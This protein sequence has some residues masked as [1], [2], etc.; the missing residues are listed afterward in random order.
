MILYVIVIFLGALLLFLVQPI[1][2]RLVLP[3]Y[4][5]TAVVW[6]TCLLFFQ[7]MLLA[8]YAYAHGS[9]RRLRPQWQ[10]VLHSLWLVSAA[11]TLPLALREFLKP[12]AGED[13]IFSILLML[14]AVVGLPFFILATTGP[15][16][17]AWQART[18]PNRSPYRLFAISNAGS[19]VA[20]MIY[21]F[22]I[23]PNI[24]LRMQT[25]LWSV[26]F[27]VFSVAM[28]GCGIRYFR[29][30]PDEPVAKPLPEIT[31]VLEPRKNLVVSPSTKRK[32]RDKHRMD[33]DWVVETPAIAPE[34]AKPVSRQLLMWILLATAPSALL[35]ATSGL[36]TQELSST[37]FLWVVPLSLYLLSFIIC[38]ENPRWYF[39]P[40]F[41]PLFFLT[42]VAAA[43]ITQAG[44]LAPFS[45]QLGSLS[46]AL[47]A[48]SVVCHGELERS[49]PDHNDLTT[50]YLTVAVG[51]AIGG[52]LVALV[53]PII[54]NQHYEFHLALVA[55]LFAGCSELL[56]DRRKK[57]QAGA[58]NGLILLGVA[59]SLTGIV[60]NSP[61]M[62][63]GDP[64]WNNL[65]RERN[66][67]GILTV[68]QD[69]ELRSL[70]HGR[71]VHG[72]QPRDARI[73]HLPISY[74]SAESGIGVIMRAMKAQRNKQGK[75][76]RVGV[77]GLGI[78]TMAA[79]SLEGD[80]FSFYEIDP[81]V[82]RLA[83][84]HFSYLQNAK[85]EMRVL[86]GDGRME[87]ERQWKESGSQNFDVLVLDAFSSDAVPTHLMTREALELYRRH[88]Q[89]DGVIVFHVTN[90]LLDLRRVAQGL[91]N[92]SGMQSLILNY[93]PNDK[94]L[95]SSTWFALTNDRNWKNRIAELKPP[96]EES[97]EVVPVLWT[98]DFSSLLPLIKW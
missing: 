3:T 55:C 88:I 54:F 71:T 62:L 66:A 41:I 33:R 63:L 92:D 36:L 58:V 91:A 67:Y 35:V 12:S 14:S 75:P 90:R 27:I 84:R 87:L 74:Y 65:H 80:Q 45:I 32:K 20:L 48:G 8:G 70:V 78:G 60:L 82:E 2:G 77:I 37:P 49:K 23:E 43:G 94:F 21:P 69:E 52:A 97:E 11:L 89:P 59:L 10:V 95:H 93:F 76:L 68:N 17:Q 38:F 30:A 22:L 81:A 42:S 56:A 73:A 24:G 83:N 29:T 50:F 31:P 64:Q 25:I 5:G 98:D 47:F 34:T 40:F 61:L 13:P 86:I 16:I 26:G 53:A 18:H 1:V 51:G 85:G 46:L 28:F 4:G 9:L 44:A 96:P 57:G 7:S 15:T 39:R 72:Y 19:L 79:W 6:T